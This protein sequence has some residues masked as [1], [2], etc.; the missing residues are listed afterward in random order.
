MLPNPWFDPPYDIH[1][2]RGQ[3]VRIDSLLMIGS[4]TAA[5]YKTAN[6]ATTVTFT[7]L[8]KC[9]LTGNIYSGLN[10]TLDTLT[11]E[12]TPIVVAPANEKHNFI[13]VAQVQKGTDIKETYIRIH[14][15]RSIQSVRLTPQTLTVQRGLTGF[16]FTLVAR[17]D[18]DVVAEI[19]PILKGNNGFAVNYNITN[20]ISIVWSSATPGLIGAV[21]GE[22]NPV[23]GEPLG[24]HN[25]SV[26]VTFGAVT[27][28]A[29][30]TIFIEDQL[31]GTNV[32]IKAELVSTGNCPGAASAGELPN[33]I[34]IPDGF[35]NEDLP[36]FNKIVDNYVSDL[37]RGKISS[38]FDVLSGSINYWK[39]QVTSRETGATNRG[40]FYVLDRGGETMGRL[41]DYPQKPTSGNAAEWFFYHL[42]FYVG[43]PVKADVTKDNAALR[44][45]WKLTS[46]VDNAAIDKIT[47]DAINNWKVV[48]NRRLPDDRDTILGIYVNDYTAASKDN[49]FDF[50]GFTRKRMDRTK[51]DTFFAT[52]KDTGNILIG[53]KFHTTTGKD[54]RNVVIITASN[55]G[56]ALNFGDG[57]FV[58]IFDRD[59]FV[60]V[61]DNAAQMITSIK[62]TDNTDRYPNRDLA[63]Y[64][65]G[66]ITHELG[67]SFSLDDEYGEPVPDPSFNNKPV[68]DPAVSGWT[69]A[70]FSGAASA[71]DWSGN[72]MA[73]GDLLTPDAGDPTKGRI[74]AN[75]IKW[76]YHRIKKCAIITANPAASGSNYTITVKP[77]QTADFVA[78]DKVFLRKSN[79]SNP[80]AIV[81]RTASP[82]AVTTS[83]T[84]TRAISKELNVESVNAGANQL[85]V[86]V[87]GGGTLSALFTAI[88][89][90]ERMILYNPVPEPNPTATHKYAEVISKKVLD[91]INTH[92]YA[93]NV[94]DQSGIKKEVIDSSAVQNS[95][96]P[97]SLVPSCSSQKKRIIGLYT[98][99]DQKHG[100]IYHSAGQCFMRVHYH[101]K[102]D[103]FCSVC[104]YTIVDRAD[105]AKHSQLDEKIGYK[106]IY[107][108]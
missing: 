78:G 81:A 106:K 66:T 90:D 82:N 105:P 47:N 20:A 32:N 6:P 13:V 108:K 16:N 44:A 64:K 103:E 107:P 34:F 91:H 56:R 63:P 24:P 38:P 68:D 36:V 43:L 76:R 77:G 99:G 89:A 53:D 93:F 73:R 50:I 74:D 4:S 80:I 97:G 79:R 10:I 94:V 52:L 87:I 61:N 23:G 86:S 71:P 7:P 42:Y 35:R 98:G 2:L 49:S 88:A 54:H 14:I 15:H 8:Y 65:K 51:L 69:F 62:F 41:I 59:R 85:T 26:D 18:D 57:F 101:G 95:N 29:L 100:H 60:R 72:V 40:E 92:P 75:K 48:G 5:D 25:A 46:G 39:V 27:R 12:I 70:I 1:L 21:S 22:I 45:G 33:V 102:L 28:S 19:G 67:H 31:S 104:K 84:I 96:I 30:G 17:F 3:S 37:V 9:T 83:D 58:D 11:G 55:T